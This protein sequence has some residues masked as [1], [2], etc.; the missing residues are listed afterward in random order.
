MRNQ[1]RNMAQIMKGMPV[2]LS[3]VL[4]T[5]ATIALLIF[6]GAWAVSADADSRERELSFAIA[7][8]GSGSG[9]GILNP[10]TV[11]GRVIDQQEDIGGY[12]DAWWGKALIK[13]CPLH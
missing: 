10:E 2:P 9:L 3:F 12:G 8:A 4:V 1:Y 5:A 13:A 11:Q 7:G 6:F